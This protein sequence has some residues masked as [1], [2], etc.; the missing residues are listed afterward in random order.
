MKYDMRLSAGYGFS[1]DFIT[2]M[3]RLIAVLSSVKAAQQY[4]A[5]ST[6]NKYK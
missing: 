1:N 4:I 6:E 5:H 3:K 2:M